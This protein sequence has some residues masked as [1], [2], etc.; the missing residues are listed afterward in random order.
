MSTQTPPS[1]RPAGMTAFIIVWI[2][3]LIS[4]LATDMTRFALT[5]W[6]FEKTGTATALALVNVFFI[7]PFLVMSPIAGAMVDRYNRKMMMMVS[8]LGAGIATVIVFALQATGNL[9]VW[10]LYVTSAITG[11]FNCFQWPAYSASISLMV[12]KEQLGRVNGMMSLMEAGPGVISPLLAGALI[13]VI[14]ITG[15]LSIDVVTFV[16]A[17]AALAFVVVPQPQQSESGR[18]A[19]GNLLSEAAYGF[20]YIF[21]RPS[22][23]GLQLVFLFGNI[24]SGIFQT[25]LAPMVLSQ[26]GNNELALGS[27]Q[28]AG[29]LGAIVGGVLMSVWGGTKRRVHG[30]LLGHIIIGVVEQIL[31]GVGRTL[32]IWVAAMALGN[33]IIP[34]LNGSNQ[35]IWQAKVAPDLQGRVFSARRLIAWGANPL[36]ALTAAFLADRIFGPAMMQPNS[37]LAN[38]FGWLVGTQPGSGMA[39]MMIFGGIGVVLVGSLGYLV[40]AVRNAEDL[41]PDHDAKAV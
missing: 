24:F 11:L 13:G 1:N 35:A 7:V 26:T 40:P 20:R 14:G 8:D 10:H 27:V 15:I 36:S 37:A 3:Q 30:V 25:L 6:A 41:L 21:A 39:L 12:P 23:L 22:L 2:G 34:W 9:E 31:F 32:P 4:I 33:M 29:A 38:N 16:L 18:Q 17:I 28:S 5:I 19:Q